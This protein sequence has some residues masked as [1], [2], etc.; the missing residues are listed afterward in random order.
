MIPLRSSI[1]DL[2]QEHNQKVWLGSSLLMQVLG[3][4][5]DNAVAM[6]SILAGS[7][8][9]LILSI[10]SQRQKAKFEE[11]KFNQELTH[12]QRMD[13]LAYEKELINLEKIKKG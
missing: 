8:V 7:I 12:K 10:R 11:L 3:F 2:L 4:F 6:I 9:P 1:T 5:A 13:D